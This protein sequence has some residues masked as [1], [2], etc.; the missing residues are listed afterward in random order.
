MGASSKNLSI[1][2]KYQNPLAVAV[3]L[4]CSFFHIMGRNM[5]NLDEVWNY[6]FARGSSMGYVIYN[7]Y[8]TVLPP[9]FYEMMSWP[10]RISRTLMTYRITEVVIITGIMYT[11]YVVLKKRV[12]WLVSLLASL[13]LLHYSDSII[14]YNSMILLCGLGLFILHYGDNKATDSRWHFLLIGVITAIPVM[15]RQTTGCI[16]LIAETVYLF[17]TGK[18]EIKKR[19]PWFLC[20]IAIPCF[21]LLFFL[22]VNHNFMGYW[23][24]CLFS[25]FQSSYANSNFVTLPIMYLYIGIDLVALILNVLAYVRE[26]KDLNLYWVILIACMFTIAIPI[27]DMG[28]IYYSVVISIVSIVY[29]VFDYCSAHIPS[30]RGS[31]IG[32]FV[33]LVSVW[34]IY[35]G[36]NVLLTSNYIDYS[37]LRDIPLG[38]SLELYED[39]NAKNK[40][41]EAQG[42]KVVIISEAKAIF[43]CLDGTFEA[44]YHFSGMSN[45]VGYVEGLPENTI[46][47]ISDSYVQNN[48]QN[49][50]VVFDYVMENYTE[51]DR[52]GKFGYYVIETSSH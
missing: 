42:Y 24:N 40:E 47:V 10:L 3:I 17:V 51:I 36:L 44:P 45:P 5:V 8:N 22:I 30:V 7:D 37:E 39:I 21:C 16:I 9:L 20:G 46:I 11:V 18:Q 12:G 41:Y 43:S 32:A 26:K 50:P 4:V 29:Y 6:C 14:T 35:S 34:I 19:L 33:A 13:V 1:S 25:L 2:N 52:Y 27:C 38:R 15:Y 48:W 49:P 23:E 28:H 31:I